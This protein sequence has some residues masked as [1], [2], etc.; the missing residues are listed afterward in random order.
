V[1][2]RVALLLALSLAPFAGLLAGAPRAAA[3][4][5]EPEGRRRSDLELAFAWPKGLEARVTCR[6]V[7]AR[8]GAP[9]RTF[10]ARWVERVAQE[11]E[12]LRLTSSG[13]RW[14]GEPPYPKGEARAALRAS[15]AIVQRVGTDGAFLG[16][17][18][19]DALRPVLERIYADAGL[20]DDEAEEAIAAFEARLVE[21][22]REGW[23][24]SVGFWIGAE[25]DLGQP[26]EKEEEGPT[27]LLPALPVR[28]RV[29][30]EARRRVPCAASE[31]QAR[32][33]ELSLR[34]EPARS[35][36]PALTRAI[37]AKLAGEGNALPPGEVR[38][39]GLATELTLVTE[40]ATLLPWRVV[41]RRSVRATLVD[42][43]GSRELEA[44]ERTEWT[45]TWTRRSSKT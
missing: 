32:C 17:E 37:V 23:N 2:R 36:L 12:E 41:S 13:T 7:S 18:N 34:A 3:Q 39:V 21:E 40:P 15:E 20:S 31:R 10:T 4:A 27:W 26:R 1:A 38:E 5:T 8:T 19:G 14:E 22:A 25:L 33:V 16:L 9:E 44:V 42:D 11:G 35:A 45:W 24:Q 28:S 29:R 43:A 30:M 6:R